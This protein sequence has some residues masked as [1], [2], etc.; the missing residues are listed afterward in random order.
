MINCFRLAQSTLFLYNIFFQPFVP[1]AETI[2]D[3]DSDDSFASEDDISSDEDE[4]DE[5]DDYT[6]QERKVTRPTSL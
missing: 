4:Y 3:Y 6:I 5:D 2:L 1:S